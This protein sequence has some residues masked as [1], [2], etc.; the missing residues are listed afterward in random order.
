MK[1]ASIIV[2]T[3]FIFTSCIPLR[4]APNIKEDKI[5]IAKKFKR[6]L[7]RHYAL[8]FKDPK[9]AD[10]FYHFV[11]AKY[12]LNDESVEDN[13]PFEIDG[14]EFSF[15]F[16]EVE[17][18]TSTINLLPMFVDAALSTEYCIDPVF[19]DLYASRKGHWYI[20]LTARDIKM[21]DGLHPDYVDRE[22]VIRHLRELRKEY[23]NTHNYMEFSM[24]N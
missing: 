4:I 24:K 20:V 16:Y 10:D 9:N 14:K 12:H 17:R 15:S 7:P 18:V 5:K 23:L 3:L 6:S 1:H 8:I 13:V 2:L 19:E 22:L 21:Q 11:N